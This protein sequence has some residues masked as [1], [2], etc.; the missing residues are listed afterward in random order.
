M[1]N[2]VYETKYNNSWALV[3]GINK[4]KCVS[5][6]CYAR[7]DAEAISQILIEKFDFP[8]ENVITL[9]DEQASRNEIMKSY[10]RFTREDVKPD[11]RILIFFAGHGHT[12]S[13]NR[14]DIGYLIPVDGE[15]QD[16]STFIRWDELTR[17]SELIKAKHLF[18]VFDACFSGLAITRSVRQGSTRYLKNM[19]QRYSVQV[20]TAGKAD[21]PVADANGP[22]PEHSIFTGHLIQALEGKAYVNGEILTANSVMSYVFDKVS[23][24]G[25]SS[26]TPH[27]GYI[28]GDGDFILKASILDD[29]KDDEQVDNDILIEISNKDDRASQNGDIIEQVKEYISDEKYK[30][31][32]DTVV[33]Q[34]VKYFLSSTGNDKMSMQSKCENESVIERLKDYEIAICNVQSILILLTHWG[35]DSHIPVMKKLLTRSIDNII[36]EGGNNVWL[37]L[38]WYPALILIYSGGISAIAAEDYKTLNRMFT[39]KIL[40]DQYYNKPNA[41]I[42]GVVNGALEIDRNDVFKIIPGYEKYYAPRSE[43]LFKF[44]QPTFD[45]ILFLGKGYEEVFDRFEILY[46]LTYM[47]LTYE[48]ISK[49]GPPGRF[50]W[51][52]KRSFGNNI[53]NDILNEAKLYGDEWSPLKAGM[54]GG[55]YER[56][57]KISTEY[58]EL[59]E[60]IGWY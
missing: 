3:I 59:L 45:D 13:G 35:L 34:E 26:Q 21:E 56:F 27:Y 5:Q 7:N 54:F 23:K 41:I 29:L 48:N 49:W 1:K 55:S 2:N 57:D 18:F 31:K 9:Y 51:K 52:F 40:C 47:D 43:Y 60:K 20:L 25:Y 28:S 44:L 6:L 36:L 53:Y 16:I 10:L 32:L 58:K 46:A 19:L 33:T 4:Y 50:A 24:D 8:K 15:L 14:N 37:N 22:I 12:I 42:V 30:I 39:T 17:N 11:D 38:R